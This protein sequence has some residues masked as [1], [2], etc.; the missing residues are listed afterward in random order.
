[1][2]SFSIAEEM[3][4][5]PTHVWSLTLEPV[6][7]TA[8][9]KSVNKSTPPLPVFESSAFISSDHTDLCVFPLPPK[10]RRTI[11]ARRCSSSVFDGFTDLSA[12]LELGGWIY[13]FIASQFALHFNFKE[14]NI[15]T[16]TITR[17]KT[18]ITAKSFLL[19]SEN[20]SQKRQPNTFSWSLWLTR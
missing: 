19:R 16:V 15:F 14:E 17:E 3:L 11:N 13:V 4:F 5:T 1:M 18:L 6:L 10:Q 20:M 12:L 9:H 2:F 7:L 8:A